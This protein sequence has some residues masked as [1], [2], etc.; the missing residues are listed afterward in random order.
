MHIHISRDAQQRHW[1]LRSMTWTMSMGIWGR[2]IGI[3]GAS[4]IVGFVHRSRVGRTQWRVGGIELA[5]KEP[6][7]ESIDCIHRD[8]VDLTPNEEYVEGRKIQGRLCQFIP[9]YPSS[10]ARF[11]RL[12]SLTALHSPIFSEPLI[13]SRFPCLNLLLYL[14]R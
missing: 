11:L 13:K 1:D 8:S 6:G 12:A 7:F 3:V 2:N 10:L 5:E 4:C 9:S 14:S